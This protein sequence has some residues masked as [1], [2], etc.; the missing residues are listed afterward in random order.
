MI[1]TL[2]RFDLKAASMRSPTNGTMP[3]AVSKATLA[4]IRAI[5]Q[6]GRPRRLASQMM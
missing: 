6:R 4:V 1:R 2:R 3:I 5:F